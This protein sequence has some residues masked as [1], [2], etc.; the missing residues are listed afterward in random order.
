[1]EA[2][3]VVATYAQAKKEKI[4]VVDEQQI[5]ASYFHIRVQ[6]IDT[7]NSIWVRQNSTGDLLCL[8]YEYF[9]ILVN[10]ILKL[11]YI[12]HKSQYSIVNV[13]D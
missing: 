2:K 10:I 8:V 7:H 6:L 9:F 3:S 5:S 11:L 4:P 12:V 13:S 1:M